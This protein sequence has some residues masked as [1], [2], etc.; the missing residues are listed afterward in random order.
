[1][2]YSDYDLE[3]AFSIN[4]CMPSPRAS[5]AKCCSSNSKCEALGI[6]ENLSNARKNE[7]SPINPY[8]AA[9]KEYII[10]KRA[11]MVIAKATGRWNILAHPEPS[12]SYEY[13]FATEIHSMDIIWNPI[14]F[15]S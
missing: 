6:N 10:L 12:S 3:A 5:S 1:M 15:L 2:A 7:V 11:G 9:P 4:P 13:L 14:N 8:I